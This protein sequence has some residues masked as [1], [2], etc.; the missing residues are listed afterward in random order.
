MNYLSSAH[1]VKLWQSLLPH[2]QQSVIGHSELGQAIVAFHQTS[3]DRCEIL[4]WSL[5]HGNETTG[6]EALTTLIQQPTFGRKSWCII[7]VLNPDGADA[8]SRMNH[9]GKDVNRDAIR[10]ETCEGQALLSLL[11]VV[12]PKLV[13]NLHDQRSC[14]RGMGS[15]RPATF[16]LLAPCSNPKHEGGFDAEASKVAG[17]MANQISHQHPH[18]GLARF[19]DRHYPNAFGDLWQSHAAT[20]T[21][22]TGITLVDWTRG[23]TAQALAM[24][25][26]TL[27]GTCWDEIFQANP[28]DYLKLPM[29]IDD[30]MDARVQTGNGQSYL[31]TYHE[32][33]Q[34][35][36]LQ[37]EWRAL[38]DPAQRA[39]A[40]HHWS[41]RLPK[42]MPGE[43]FDARDA[44]RLN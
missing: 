22:E 25:L 5:M 41:S 32:A 7:P 44:Q 40:W 9:H 17:W 4:A 13:L 19:N 11:S 35:G 37:A 24:L 18:W 30:A 20:V 15:D 33:L 12:Q 10:A 8:F 42:L 43:V 16:S 27:D 29:N 36:K 38:K 2:W 31:L 26:V 39:L 21:L 1:R 6:A 14:F 34:Q 23:E 3:L 28:H